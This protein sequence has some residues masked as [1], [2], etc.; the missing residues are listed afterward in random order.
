[1]NSLSLTAWLFFFLI[2]FWT[3]PHFWALAI[4]Y[5]DDYAAAGIPMLPVVA[6]MRS[7]QK[8]MW[9]HTLL[10]IA[11]SFAVLVSAHFPWWSYLVTALLA[12]GFAS[13]L[14][15]ISGANAEQSAVKLFQWSIT[16]LSIYSFMLTLATVL[17]NR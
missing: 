5:K 9:F 16:Y 6:T 10:M 14:F 3:P 17:A 12:V 1:T 11:T 7:V 13:Q 4:K 8:Q 15:K 2:F